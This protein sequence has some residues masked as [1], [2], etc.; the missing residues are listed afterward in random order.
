MDEP[1]KRAVMMARIC[2]TIETL[3]LADVKPGSV[4][5]GSDIMKQLVGKNHTVLIELFGLRVDYNTLLADDEVQVC[6]KFTL[7]GVD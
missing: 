2:D 4:A 5:F 1:E 7:D 6:V 3:K